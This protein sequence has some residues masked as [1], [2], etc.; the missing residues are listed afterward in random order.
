MSLA[1]THQIIDS[2]CHYDMLLKEGLSVSDITDTMKSLS[3]EGF[4]QISTNEEEVLFAIKSIKE[5]LSSLLSYTIGFHPNDVGKL[6]YFP[7][8]KLIEQYQ[9]DL[10][11]GAVG[12]VGLDYFYE[13]NSSLQQL[14]VGI[15]Q[16][17]LKIAHKVS[18]PVC[19]HTRDAHEDTILCLKEFAHTK[20]LIHCF[21]GDSKQMKDYL[22]LGCYISFS[23]IVTFK[24]ATL[25]QEAAKICPPERMLVETDAPF[26]TPIPY[27]GQTNQ[28]GYTRYVLDYI[29][30][31]KNMS[32][33]DLAE[34]T[35]SN[36]KSFYGIV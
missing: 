24:N 4:V 36:T 13:K 7:S 14:Q 6:D 23:G 8:L 16:E 18:R 5:N 31:L 32:T 34:I 2:H 11:F 3:V 25:V 1:L 9:S 29:A 17:F 22:D 19:V 28:P 20:T 15:F 27:R 30:K 12:E 26:L 33:Y 21:T 10:K 35:Y